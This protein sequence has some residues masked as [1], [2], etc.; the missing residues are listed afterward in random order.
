VALAALTALTAVLAVRL[1]VGLGSE[2]LET[3]ADEWLYHAV[4]LGAAGLCL[5][6]AITHGGRR[7][8]WALLGA[9]FLSWAAG[10]VYWTFFLDVEALPAFSFADVLWLAFY[11]PVYAALVLLRRGRQRHT[12]W[13]D[14]VIVALA[15]GAV[16]AAVVFDAVLRAT[17]D[18]HGAVVAANLAYPLADLILLGLVAGVLA[19]SGWRSGR[20]WALI[21]GGLATFAVSD[22]IYL[23]QVAVDSYAVGTPVDLGWVAAA[24]LVAWAAWQPSPRT[25]VATVEGARV[26]L[27]PVAFAA[28]ALGILVFDHFA[29][30]QTLAL[31]LAAG[32][33]LAVLFRLVLT[34]RE[35]LALIASAREEARTDALTGLGNRRRLLDDLEERL[36]RGGATD[37]LALLDLNGFKLYN[38]TFGHAAGDALLARVG[39]S[40]ALAAGSS[41]AAYRM[42][43]DEFCVLLDADAQEGDGL[44]TRLAAA[45]RQ[46]GEG[47]CVSAS[48]GVAI[49]GEE[50][51]SA[52]AAL[53]LADRRMY[54]RKPRGRR[55]PA[56]VAGF[57]HERRA[58]D[59][60]PVERPSLAAAA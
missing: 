60:R 55:S 35:K 15:V 45:A 36:R 9:A 38:D 44:V 57:T 33:L 12:V 51:T 49:L 19:V 53:R 20:S 48:V 2:R 1:T 37:V 32:G 7:L 42:G 17:G 59:G 8:P 40:L 50:A 46:Q 47:S 5:A 23:Y 21:A 24:V 41:G 22:S 18:E 31:V 43:G 3:F 6:R 13:L 39:R 34:F 58:G 4:M 56:A 11:P 14:G 29:R 10:S 30:V 26:L 25:R 28:V 16:G 27:T 54:E 52:S